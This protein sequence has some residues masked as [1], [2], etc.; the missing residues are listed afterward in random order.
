MNLS[1][2][3]IQKEIQSLEEE[4]MTRCFTSTPFDKL[5]LSLGRNSVSQFFL[6]IQKKHQAFSWYGFYEC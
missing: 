6:N 3:N 1:T 4:K 2:V 5:E